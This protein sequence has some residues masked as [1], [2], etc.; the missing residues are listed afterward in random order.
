[1]PYEDPMDKVRQD[2][3]YRFERGERLKEKQ[4]QEKEAEQEKYR[5]I[6]EEWEQKGE[7]EK[8][9]TWSMPLDNAKVQAFLVKIMI[10]IDEFIKK[11]DIL[12][13][14]IEGLASDKEVVII[15]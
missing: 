13:K 1:M 12:E 4:K 2:D 5:K 8:Q 10:K 14:K 15:E 6:Q 9:I 3:M 11:F 7:Y